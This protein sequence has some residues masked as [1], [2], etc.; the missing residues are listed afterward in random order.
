[1]AVPRIL[2]IRLS[3]LGDVVMASGLI[4]AIR[5]LHPDAHLAWLTEPPAAPLLQHN[6][7]LNEVIVWPKEHWKQLWKTRQWRALWAELRAFRQRL[8]SE[9]FDLV[10]DAQGLLKSGVCAWLTGAPRRIGLLSREGSQ[11]LMHETIACPYGPDDDGM[12]REYRVLAKFLG[13]SAG[14]FWPSV[15]PGQAAERAAQQALLAHGLGADDSRRHV[16]IAPFTTRAQKHWFADHWQ[17]LIA[18]MQR[19]GLAVVMLGGPGDQA[20]ADK[21]ATQCPGLVNLVGQLKLNESAAVIASSRLMVGVDTGLT[22]M[23]TAFK[24]PTVALFGSTRPYLDG[25]T[26]STHVMYD[27]LSCA[28]CRR[29]PTCGGRFTCMRQLTPERVWQSAQALM[30]SHA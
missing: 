15:V 17:A 24:R 28:P 25:R 2:I 21:L 22:H 13:A 20:E 11:V 19:Q 7:G 12:S 30:E 29:H 18:D 3:A 6:P 10:L 5:A 1:L 14:T 23:G 4:P 26:A 9:R 8:H 27:A 16:V